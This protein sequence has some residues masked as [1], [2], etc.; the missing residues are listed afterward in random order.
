MSKPTAIIYARVST[1]RQA[2]DGL[3]VDSQIERG[4]SKA[5]LLDADVLRVFT[6][7]G[8]SGRTDE[9]PAFQDAVRYC[10]AH[11]VQFFICWSTSRFARNKLDAALYKRELEKSGTRVVYVSVD[12]DNRT[13]S[14]WML[15]SM[16]E[17][18]DEH[19]SRQVSS[20]TLRSMIK[21]ASDGHFNGGRVPLGFS[22]VL[23][24]KRKRLEINE[25]EVVLVR[26]IFAIYIGGDGAKTIATVLNLQGRLNRGRKW[27]KS[28]ILNLLRNMIYTGHV[29]FNRTNNTTGAARPREEWII[30][31]SHE[32]II[33]EEIFMEAQK[34]IEGRAPCDGGGSPHSGFVFTGL[35]KCGKCGASLQIESAK[36]RGR[37][38]HYYNCSASQKGTGCS[39]RRIS[40]P[41]FDAWLVDSVM[42]RIL[43]KESITEMINDMHEL[44]GKWIKERA[45]R[46]ADTVK[47]LRDTETKLQNLY[48]VLEL[49]GKDAPNLGDLTIRMRELKA[50]RDQFEEKLVR[51]EEEEMPDVSIGDIE[52]QQMTELMREIVATTDDAK[53]LRQFFSTFIEKVEV[54]AD[55]AVIYYDRSKVMNRAG[56][57]TVHSKENWL[58]DRFLL[59]TKF[60]I[61]PFPDRFIRK[62]A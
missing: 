11:G 27:S 6:D 16:M 32:P 42:S 1:Q 25:S 44:T 28:T 30:T 10:K 35:L 23:D 38:Y 21:N 12:L 31:K 34:L 48:S 37:Y 7:A 3:P 57:D 46:R 14:G 51:L 50:Q 15:E 22:T 26:D 20:D 58:P 60:I 52:I 29:V 33:D 55:G 24:G 17:I 2:D 45:A 8:I 39:S 61:I 56:V 19:Y 41:E 13:D 5:L 9:R 53:R 43:S 18:F 40:A 4:H 36:G 62:V 49:H 54:N 47:D 59:R